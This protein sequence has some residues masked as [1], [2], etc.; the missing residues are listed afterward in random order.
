MGEGKVGRANY[1]SREKREIGDF[2]RG[3][4]C[5]ARFADLD[6]TAEQP[7]YGWYGL[8]GFGQIQEVFR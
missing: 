2:R 5:L 7:S 3:K 8:N 4:L 6:R 1:E